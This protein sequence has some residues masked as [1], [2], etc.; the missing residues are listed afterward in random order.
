MRRRPLLDCFFNSQHPTLYRRLI[1]LRLCTQAPTR[2][3]NQHLRKLRLGLHVHRTGRTLR[4]SIITATSP[5]ES[6]TTRDSHR[7]HR[8]HPQVRIRRTQPPR[9]TRTSWIPILRRRT[10]LHRPSLLRVHTLAQSSTRNPSRKRLSFPPPTP[11]NHG[12]TMSRSTLPR[13][14]R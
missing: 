7:G 14:Q 8:L 9:I 11:S 5:F 12:R 2:H 3:S 6:T 1:R 10:H 4:L 13:S